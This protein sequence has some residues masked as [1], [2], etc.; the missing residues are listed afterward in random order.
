[1]VALI[2]IVFGVSQFSKD[3]DENSSTVFGSGKMFDAIAPRYDITNTILS[4]GMHAGW[5]ERMIAA[6]ELQPGWFALIC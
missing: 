1:M 6:L 5:R 3:A 4:L 2:A